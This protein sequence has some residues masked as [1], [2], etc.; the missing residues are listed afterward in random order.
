VA[1]RRVSRGGRAT[2]RV[3]SSSATV[4]QILSNRINFVDILKCISIYETIGYRFHSVMDS[5][6]LECIDLIVRNLD[7]DSRV[8]FALTSI[9]YRDRYLSTSYLRRM[10]IKRM[11]RSLDLH[12]CHRIIQKFCDIRIRSCVCDSCE[13]KGLTKPMLGNTLCIESCI[14]SCASCGV[15]YNS[16]LSVCSEVDFGMVICDSCFILG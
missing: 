10:T 3:R 15:H 2:K 14:P 7:G 6:P 16:S 11:R 4:V 8:R 13:R 12:A 9:S 1:P 5:L